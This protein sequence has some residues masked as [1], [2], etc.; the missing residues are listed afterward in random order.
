MK[1]YDLVIIGGGPAGMAA[2]VSARE[3]G[4]RSVLLV[5]RSKRMGGILPQCIH[6]GFG[7]KYLGRSVTGP[8]YAEYWIHRSEETG[9]SSVV[10]CDVTDL[11]FSRR[12]CRTRHGE[13]SSFVLKLVSSEKGVE[14][15]EAKAVI[16][17]SGCR[18][19]TRGQLK[20]P[21]SRPSGVYTA[22]QVQYMMN[23]QNLLPGNE[24]VI[25]GSGDIGL[26]MARRMKWE[27]MNVRLVLGERASGLIRN[28]IQCV[29]DWKIPI[30][31]GYTVLSIHGRNRVTGVTV[32]P[33]DKN[34]RPKIQ[35]KQEIPC[36]TLVIA[37]GLVPEDDIWNSLM[38]SSGR[39]G[40]PI[41][42]TDETGTQVEGFFVCGNVIRQYDT[43]DEVT[44]SGWEAGRQA[45]RY[46]RNERRLKRAEDRKVAALEMREMMS[47]EKHMMTDDDL[48]YLTSENPEDA[49]GEYL[50][51]CINCP[52]GCR[53][54]IQEDGSVSG[55]R[56][57][58]GARYAVSEKNSPS[59]I[60]TTT[61]GIKGHPERLIP[62]R[63][64]SAVPKNRVV[65][66]LTAC[67]KRKVR[68]PVIKSSILIE[69]VLEDGSDIHMISCASY[70]ENE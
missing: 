10:S 28:Y 20:I 45:A 6:D 41:C 32:A 5:E 49:E 8:E 47:S 60:V 58:Q 61:I 56:C 24:V 23:V 16:L 34:G 4:I 7:M 9:I 51:Y 42:S 3:N 40:E 26:I 22:G 46:L 30:R 59:R 64:S 65:E 68:L 25:L 39:A 62:V 48:M 55:N 70:T 33:V 29:H 43:V 63:S 1:Q 53:M 11:S 2:A 54:T 13:K 52:S 19:R 17:A 38:E 14:E 67:R 15:A 31:F 27:G 21:G 57:S 36:D 44:A 66:V 50:L 37:A 12:A 69:D 35:G 18:E